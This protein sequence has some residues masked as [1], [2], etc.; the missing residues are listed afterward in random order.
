MIIRIQKN[1]LTAYGTIWE[2]D[3]RYFLE[4][5]ARLER[6][7]SEITIHLHTPGG[8]VFDGNLI[9]NALNKSASFVHIVID[10]IAASMGAIIILSAKKVSIVENGYI[11][12]HAPASYSNGDADTFEKEAKLLRSVEKNFIEKLS[13]R[14]GKPIKEVEKWLVGENWFDAKEA[15]QLGFVTDIIPAQTTTLLPIDNVSSMGEQNVYNMY[16]GLFATLKTVNI[17][18]KNMKS[19]LVNSLVQALSLSGISEESSETAVLQAIQERI[20]N[21]K[22]AREKAENALN[23][24]K[25]AQITAVIEN[26]IKSGKITEAQKAVYEKIAETSG[27]EALTTV[28]ENTAVAGGKQAI[29]APNISAMLQANS[30]NAGARASWDF[31][32][33]QKEDPKGLEKL[34][35]DQPERFKE[36]FNAKYKK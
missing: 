19:I 15:K 7:Y 25:K 35:V 9:Y 16:A 22:V 6:D 21:E 10:G 27:V 18:D 32:Q 26:A 3:G 20:T 29:Q 14:T 33:W 13:A 17:S 23:A 11:M 4:E 5:F 36:L 28:L 1:I 8:S 24:F 34:S 31:D 30:G 12:L 2:G